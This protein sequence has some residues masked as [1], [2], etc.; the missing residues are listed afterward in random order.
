[1]PPSNTPI[2]DPNQTPTP[3]SRS[4]IVPLAIAT[5][6]GLGYVPFAPGTFGSAAGLLVWWLLGPSAWVQAAAI[7]VIFAAGVWS[8]SA[9]ERHFCRTDPGHVIVDE[10]VGM[11]MTL[12]LNPVGWAGAFGGFLLF[13]IAD[14]I[15]PY[16]ANRFEQL[17]GGLGVMADDAMAGVY[18]NLALRAA[19][20]L[21]SGTIMTQMNR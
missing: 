2:P 3:T 18:A 9:C 20:A 1:V 15:K 12:W 4:T 8:S 19:L 10:V 13:R 5:V 14:V 16:P 7:V 6:G 21:G 17:H 11:L